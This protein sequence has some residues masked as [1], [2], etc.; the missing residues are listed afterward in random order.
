MTDGEKTP[1]L[2]YL[3]CDCICHFFL[4]LEVCITSPSLYIKKVLR[5][6]KCF[7]F[8]IVLATSISKYLLPKLP[9]LKE[10]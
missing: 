1:E 2:S 3:T 7:F 10:I 6:S 9:L 4:S 5:G 8:D